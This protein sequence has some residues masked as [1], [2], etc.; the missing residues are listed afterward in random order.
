MKYKF[1]M[2]ATVLTL[3]LILFAGCTG[4]NRNTPIPG[5]GGTNPT[6]QPTTIP[7]PE[8]TPAPTPIPTPT[9]AQGTSITV[10]GEFVE[11]TITNI[12]HVSHTREPITL[13]AGA[14]I[15]MLP[16]GTPIYHL[17]PTGAFLTCRFIDGF[18]GSNRH[19]QFMA[20]FEP[21]F[22]SEWIR[23]MFGDVN[24][25]DIILM[26]NADYSSYNHLLA[27]MPFELQRYFDPLSLEDLI[28]FWY[29]RDISNHDIDLIT[30]FG[31]V[32]YRGIFG[33]DP[34]LIVYT[35]IKY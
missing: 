2:S 29:P 21:Y 10:T 5:N 20:D 12:R 16:V 35:D 1:I 25:N 24:A 8:P 34:F 32:L 13:F 30:E 33:A 3:V 17:P 19:I 15:E 14:G 31:V 26:D 11:Y 7:T 6:A 27:N 9:P 4:G 23:N 28:E 22:N 18:V